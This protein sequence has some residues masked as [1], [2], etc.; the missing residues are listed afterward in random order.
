VGGP[1]AESAGGLQ[2]PGRSATAAIYSLVAYPVAVA[3]IAEF[4]IPTGDFAM[5]ETLSDLDG[6]AVE[7]ERVVA[8]T[9]AHVMPYVWIEV[10]DVD[11]LDR[12]LSADPSIEEFER[13]SETDESVLYRMHW[14]ENVH[15]LLK[16]LLEYEG[17]ILSAAAS[18]EGW[19]LR[20]LFP[21]RECVSRTYEYAR[22]SGLS[23]TLSTIF[24]VEEGREGRFGLTREQADALTRA[25]ERGFFKV[26]REIDLQSLADEFGISHQSL[27]ERLRRAQHTLNANTVLVGPREEHGSTN[28]RSRRI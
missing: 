25:T 6:I 23:L 19:Q 11:A 7:I 22:D 15:F 5:Y 1:D 17:T 24:E 26:P 2:D 10:D 16:V 28:G 13:V 21:S 12:A 8:H 14:I 3:T 27:S 18:T 4:D 9:E 20:A